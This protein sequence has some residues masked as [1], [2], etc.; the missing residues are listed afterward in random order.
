MTLRSIRA[1][2]GTAV[3]LLVAAGSAGP[4]S[5]QVAPTL[6]LDPA[7]IVAGR[8]FTATLLNCTP[9]GPYLF[10]V[11]NAAGGMSSDV[12]PNEV[13]GTALLA[14]VTP[15]TY[16]VAAK[17]PQLNVVASA[18]LTVTAAGSP[19]TPAAIC[20][21]AIA[22]AGT[23]VGTYGRYKLVQAPAQGRAGNDVV[24]GTAG[25]D[26]LVGGSGNDVLCGLGGDDV[27]LGGSGNDHLDGGP[28]T[29]ALSGGS[30]NDTSIN[31]ET[32]D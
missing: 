22:E 6:H 18:T 3:A 11:S 24:V 29:D 27:L 4:G 25:D 19:P 7:T 15:G 16:T 23:G 20:S 1:L 26:V 21:L 8:G 14:P 32:N 13:A 28:D 2:V 17:D 30:G 5:A 10:E 12:C 31:G 9:P